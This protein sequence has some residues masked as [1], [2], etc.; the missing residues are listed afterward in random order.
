MSVPVA[1]ARVI[2]RISSRSG[3][4][5]AAITLLSALGA[6]SSAD[7][8]AS[9]QLFAGALLRRT[10]LHVQRLA[11]VRAHAVGVVYL[12]GG[13]RGRISVDRTLDAPALPRDRAKEVSWGKRGVSCRPIGSHS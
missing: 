7:D 12:S 9:G 4:L 3:A 13:A 2:M 6:C 10:S 8:A 1:Y 5:L 11:V